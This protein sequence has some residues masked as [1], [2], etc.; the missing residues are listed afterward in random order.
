MCTN[1]FLGRF[2]LV[3]F[4]SL[5][6]AWKR[7]QNTSFRGEEELQYVPPSLALLFSRSLFLG[8]TPV[9]ASMGH[10]LR[11]GVP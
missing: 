10:L 11:K 1:A 7:D 2:G 9:R 6:Y 8:L 5:R 3:T 4:L